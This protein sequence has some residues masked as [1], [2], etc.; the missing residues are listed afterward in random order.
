MPDVFLPESFQRFPAPVLGALK[1]LSGL[2]GLQQ[3][4][5][6]SQSTSAIEFTARAL[7]GLS[8]QSRIDPQD[9]QQIPKT[10]SA[11]LV[12]NHPYGLLEGFLF[13]DMLARVR[14]DVKFLANGL[15]AQIPELKDVVIPVEVFATG[16]NC[17][18][19]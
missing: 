8:I 9:L 16:A 10:G 7:K 14:Q 18:S 12:A 4:Y 5:D 2:E 15:L 11:I 13:T 19:E 6:A 3:L 1:K 17:P